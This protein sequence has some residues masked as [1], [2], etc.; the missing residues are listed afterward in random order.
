[1]G[2]TLDRL[3][4][5][6]KALTACR[7]ECPECGHV[8][9]AAWTREED[10]CR[11]RAC[12]AR[13]RFKANTYRPLTKGMT[14]EERRRFYKR[15]VKRV[16]DMTPEEHERVLERHRAVQARYR[17]RHREE[18]RARGREQALAYYNEHRDEINARRR[19]RYA[20]NR[21]EINERRRQ[22]RKE[23]AIA[24]WGHDA[25]QDEKENKQ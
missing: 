20:E 16:A 3:M 11:C 12:G 17:E 19:A 8:G 1:M 9:M 14:E 24:K 10:A 23:R 25:P 6:L 13:F 7:T 22:W 21:D 5:E 18:I 15:N 2:E 4:G